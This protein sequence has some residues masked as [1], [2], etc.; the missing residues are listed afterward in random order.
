MDGRTHHIRRLSLDVTLTDL[1]QALFLRPRVEELAARHL[2]RVLER[3]LDRMAP[4]GMHVRLDRLDLDLGTI[5][6]D[7]LEGEA[8]AVFERALTEALADAVPRALHAP[9]AGAAALDSAAA[10]LDLADTYLTG[11]VYPFWARGDALPPPVL[12]NRLAAEQPAAL[13]GL[14]RRR[15]REPAVLERLVQQMG[16]DG[17]RRLLAAL[18]PADAAEI[19]A[20]LAD[21]VVIHR[22]GPLLP[23]PEP[24]VERLFWLVTLDYL[25]REAGSQFNRRSFLQ[26]LLAGAAER[27]GVAYPALLTLLRRTLESAG[28][29]LPLTSSLPG[30]LRDLLAEEEALPHPG[31]APLRVPA[32]PGDDGELV[33]LLRRH[34]SSPAVLGTLLHRLTPA[35]FAALIRRLE[36]EQAALILDYLAGLVLAHRTEALA[37]LSPE[38]F[39][40][41]ARLLTVAHL[42]RDPGSQ[43]NRRSWLRAVL[44][45]VAA[46]EHTPYRRM[47]ALLLRS[48]ARTAGRR[49]AAFGLPGLV[50]ELAQDEG[51]PLTPGG[52]A[53][54]ADDTGALDGDG[55]AALRLVRGMGRERRR[56]LLARTLP[57]DARWLGGVLAALVRRHRAVRL[58]PMTEAAFADLAWTMA[59]R[60]AAR[61]PS[62]A[63]ASRPGFVA[64]LVDDLAAHAGQD[65]AGLAALLR[66]TG[67]GERGGNG[68]AD[69][70]L[71]PDLPALPVP[72]AAT[73]LERAER[74]LRDGRPEADGATLALLLVQE[75]GELTFLLR[76]LVA[77]TTIPSAAWSARLDRLLARLVPEDVA[78]L[79]DPER[80]EEASRWV[81]HA[82]DGAA[83]WRLVLTALL[84]GDALDL[85]GA[86]PPGWRLDRQAA[87]RHWLDHGAAPWWAGADGMGAEAVARAVTAL[88]DQGLTG[89]LA[90]FHTPDTGQ[91]IARLRRA[92]A[93]LGRERGLLLLRR[94]APQ[95]LAPAGP[96]AGT[97]GTGTDDERLLAAVA[98]LMAGQAPDAAGAV[99]P[100]PAD[101]AAADPPPP[102]PAP[103]AAIPDAR[104]LAWLAGDID[105]PVPL[106]GAVVRALA[107]LLDA[108]GSGLDTA[109]ARGLGRETVRARWA[110]HLPAEILGRLL[111]RLEPGL[112][113]FLTEAAAVLTAAWQQAA[114]AHR[115]GGGTPA[116]LVWAVLL[117]RL[118]AVAPGHRTAHA[119]VAGVAAA[120]T[121]GDAATAATVL[122]RAR[123][124][125]REA[126]DGGLAAAL[127]PHPAPH[128][129]TPAVPPS[130]PPAA[131]KPPGWRWRSK[132]GGKPAPGETIHVANAGLVLFTP[133]LPM[134]FDRLGVL[135][136]GDDGTPRITGAEAASRAVHRLQYL[137]DGRC[138][139]PEPALVLNKL[140]CGLPLVTPIAAAA[141]MTDDDRTLCDGL[142]RAVIGNWPIIS[143]TSPAGLQ[144]TFVQREGRLEF[145]GDQWTLTVQRKTVDV[146]FDRM[147]WSVAVVYHRWMEGPLHVTW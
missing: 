98:A 110:A 100:P 146:L 9:G 1:D 83:A 27:E 16:G 67:A 6:A 80:T 90:L 78:T 76:R 33:A 120:L 54:A 63:I 96:L 28:R 24:A 126:G 41:L 70:P 69:D 97:D 118:H 94:L 117:A 31:A 147:P 77:D 75:P 53:E 62:G 65:A 95:A 129:V 105:L 13:A 130:G 138:G 108:G 8:L 71:L 121:A 122:A 25:L 102:E 10:R 12:L 17:L 32:T 43:F 2:P 82:D 79:L 116:A 47:L 142:L 84:C 22:A 44:E 134:L 36:P 91:R 57:A 128:P 114:P 49:P 60:R 106:D 113:A 66:R 119:L 48:L 4:P 123:F 124:L 15:G 21:L 14:I 18:A 5:P 107:A 86:P 58:L 144:E 137:A 64:G 40:A 140:L 3:V 136:P 92:L 125:A 139:A 46:A 29:R 112:A 7:G 39:E 88:P 81:R 72:P 132:D 115:R 50:A 104:L 99:A 131:P 55:P 37:L 51:V 143:N 74:F 127:Q 141:P 133:F 93:A 34:A 87:V 56:A 30:V 19:L 11:G 59:L 68:A 103:P 26:A 109:L 73:L 52:R 89:I 61:A 20:C 23:L 111:H 135:T 85:G 42:L 35:R 145:T 38:G 45:G 101:P